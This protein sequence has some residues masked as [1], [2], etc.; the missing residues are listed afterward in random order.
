M[1]DCHWTGMSSITIL[2]IDRSVLHEFVWNSTQY[3]K[4]NCIIN[5]H[6]STVLA[7]LFSIPFLMTPSLKFSFFPVTAYWIHVFIKPLPQYL[8]PDLSPS[9]QIPSVHM[10]IW[11]L[12]LLCASLYSSLHWNTFAIRLSILPIWRG[13]LEVQ[14]QAA[15]VTRLGPVVRI[16]PKSPTPVPVC[17]PSPRPKSYL[18]HQPTFSNPCAVL[19]RL[20]QTYLLQVQVLFWWA[21]TVLVLLMSCTGSAYFQVA[22]NMLYSTFITLGGQHKGLVPAWEWGIWNALWIKQLQERFL[23]L[24]PPNR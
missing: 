10:W 1:V 13:P 11:N 4:C 2:T 16:Q 3:S 24:Q 21:S 20:A 5:L 22:A 18:P 23:L 6:R 9:A 17:L 12:L 15:H 19:P 7:A 8:F 14:I